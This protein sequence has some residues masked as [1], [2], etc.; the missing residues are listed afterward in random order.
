MFCSRPEYIELLDYIGTDIVELSGNHNND[1]GRERRHLFAGSVP[2]A[3][4][5]R[6]LRGGANLE[7]ARQPAK[8]EH[9]GNQLA[10]IGCNPVGPGGAWAT[11]RPAR[12]GPLRRLRL[13][14]GRP[15][16]SCATKAT[17]PS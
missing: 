10:F 1:W 13:D 6:S 3:R 8:I 4:L 17:C 11:D 12:R 16:A 2:R 14:A 9:N 15:S 7:E 5:D